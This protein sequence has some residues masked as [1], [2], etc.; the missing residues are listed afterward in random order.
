MSG[1]VDGLQ[2][3]SCKLLQAWNLRLQSW[4]LEV[5]GLNGTFGALVCPAAN[6]GNTTYFEQLVMDNPA[7]HELLVSVWRDFGGLLCFRGLFDTDL[8]TPAQFVAF[9]NTFGV[10]EEE[11]DDSKKEFQVSGNPHVMRIGNT[12]DAKTGKLTALLANSA[13]LP[14]DGSPQYNVDTRRPVWHTDSTYRHLPPIGSALFCKQ[15]PPEGGATCFSNTQ[16]AYD[17]LDQGT[18]QRLH[19]L[20]CV[21]SLMHH[22]AKVHSYSQDYPVIPPEK[23]EELRA[24]NPP[25]RVPMI[26]RH[27]ITGRLALYGMNSSTCIVVPKGAP[28][29]REQMDRFDLNA[30]ED[31]SVQ[32]EWRDMLPF[33]T[34]HRFTVKWQWKVGDLVLWDNR[35][36]IHCAT[37]YN[38][39]EYTREMWRITLATD[40]LSIQKQ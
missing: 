4:G 21:C 8:F 40:R 19:S 10:V 17:M 22:D 2:P 25:T 31:P 35:S 24:A 11:L 14:E 1:P 38:T 37:G 32:K 23:A 39:A 9:G 20:E 30:Y 33:V 28:V 27:P 3:E 13:P 7:L 5:H 29:S 36:T 26:L 16:Q 12:R 6:H 18:Q 15:A 34:S